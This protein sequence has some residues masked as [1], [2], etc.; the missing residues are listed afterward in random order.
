M[1][2]D[3]ISAIN[4]N[5]QT[6]IL[7]SR[8]S[9]FYRMNDHYYDD[10]D[11]GTSSWFDESYL[12]YQDILKRSF[13][14]KI[15]EI[16]CGKASILRTNK[17]KQLNYSGCDFSEA[18]LSSNKKEFPDAEFDVITDP[19]QI[20]FKDKSFDVVFSVFV[21]EHVVRP[22]LF[23]EELIRIT[24]P[25]GQ[26]I[27]QCPDFFGRLSITSQ[28]LGKYPGTGSQKLKKGYLL[29]T[30]KT[31]IIGRVLMPVYFLWQLRNA[32]N[33]PVFLL[34]NSP[35]CFSYPFAPD[36]DAVYVTHKGEIFTKLTS[37]GAKPITLEVGINEIAS[38]NNLLYLVFER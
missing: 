19:K 21:I 14:K 24:K 16:G 30:I 38:R 33:K 28:L 9:E 15:C 35:S 10:I 34:N 8:M 22:H 31:V 29:E 11:F 27:I 1:T 4:D 23:L 36:V 17:I 20:P 5:Q 13:N 7:E 6:N 3:Y 25:G 37:L 2:I 32:H 12:M 18:L 26:I